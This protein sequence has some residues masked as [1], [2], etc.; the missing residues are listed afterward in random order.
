MAIIYRGGVTCQ[1]LTEKVLLIE[2]ISGFL[3]LI[4]DTAK[5]SKIK[6]MVMD[7]L[8]WKKSVTINRL[9][10]DL[11]IIYAILISLLCFPLLYP[12]IDHLIIR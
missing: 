5:I 9:L 6:L 8:L 7:W 2:R 4:R 3:T 11:T 10:I 12:I 1:T